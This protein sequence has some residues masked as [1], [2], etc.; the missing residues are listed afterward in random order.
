MRPLV[1]ASEPYISVSSRRSSACLGFFWGEGK[2]ML[3][4]ILLGFVSRRG[5]M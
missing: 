3:K 2:G 5:F 4:G 1:V